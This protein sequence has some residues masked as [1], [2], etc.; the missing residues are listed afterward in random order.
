MKFAHDFR[1]VLSSEDFP[2]HWVNSAIPYGK[3][4]KVLK[5]V[6][7]ELSD[8]GFKP[9]TIRRL[10]DSTTDSPVALRYGLDTTENSRRLRPR[11]VVIVYRQNGV[12]ASGSLSP[13]SYAFLEH[14][15]LVQ[16]QSCYQGGSS[17][18]KDHDGDP[19]IP[20][21]N[22]P[23]WLHSCVEDM[24][25]Q[26]EVPLVSDT[27]FFE[28]L[29]T[30][31]SGLEVLQAQEEKSM[32]KEIVSLGQEVAHLTKPS[33]LSKNDLARWRVIFEL[34]LEAQIF[35]STRERDRG[36]RS[37]HEAAQRL[38][39]FQDEVA[40]RCVSS[41]F[42]MAKSRD[43]LLRF[44]KLNSVL[45][46]NVRFQELNR[47]AVRKILKK[48][49]KRTSLGVSKKF[50][51]Q[52]LSDSLLAGTMAKGICSQLSTQLISVVPRLDDFLCPICFV[53]AYRPVRLACEHVFC[54]R[55]I[56]KMQRRRERYCPLCRADVVMTCSAECLDVDL[57][58]HM[59]K[60]FR[61][62]VKEKAQANDIE[63]GIE[64]YGPGY[65]HSS[66]RMM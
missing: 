64:D 6:I 43:A 41:Q 31:V 50:T 60:Y 32:R 24:Q 36:S 9:E 42:K 35:F 2:L 37:S 65:V 40:K 47:T 19:P 66:C 48:F 59:R 33:R 11:L 25:E 28:I 4:K 45:L 22:S 10:L 38:R 16:S 7:R 52:F 54:I 21:A 18:G 15:A 57:E 61:R 17:P 14:L 8:F 34:Y 29:Q 13:S 12:V 26:I 39:W 5:K 49:D 27:T 55:C 63:R 1:E 46:K 53:I 3:L 23:E 56:V 30:D 62:E 51:Q 58:R 20:S 44:T